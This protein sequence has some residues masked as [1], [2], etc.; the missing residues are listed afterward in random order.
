MMK[1]WRVSCILLII[2]VFVPVSARA[3]S[4]SEIIQ[5]HVQRVLEVLRNPARSKAAKEKEIWAIIDEIFDYRELS[6]RA[7][8]NYWKA[9]TPEQQEEFTHLFKRVLGNYYIDRIMAYKDEKAVFGREIKLSEDQ[10]EIRSEVIG[11]T[12]STPISYRMILVKEQW[13]VYDVV[14]EGVSLVMNYRSQFREILSN[15]SPEHLLKML[16]K[17][18]SQQEAAIL[19]QTSGGITLMPSHLFAP[20]C[21]LAPVATEGKASR[22]WGEGEGST[23]GA[24]E[25]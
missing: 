4:P 25:S 20:P 18:V 16:R 5:A 12:G 22:R 21:L 15:K 3:E 7:L 10:V 6:K 9:F 2:L 14:I 17:K 24:R 1:H 8:A 13:K 19:I 11:Q 23:Q